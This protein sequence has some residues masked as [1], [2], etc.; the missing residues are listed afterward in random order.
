MVFV[1]EEVSV[2]KDLNIVKDSDRAIQGVATMHFIGEG[3]K[4]HL[5]LKVLPTLALIDHDMINLLEHKKYV[6]FINTTPIEWVL[7]VSFNVYPS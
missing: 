2:G 4:E 5:L 7:G 6:D 1:E 3:D